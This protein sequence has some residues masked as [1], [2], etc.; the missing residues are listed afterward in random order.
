MPDIQAITFDVGGTLIKPWPSVGHVYARAASEHGIS[1]LRPNDLNNCF[2]TAWKDLGCRAETKQDWADIVRATFEGVGRPG[3]PNALFET[4][5]ARFTEPQSWH[6]FEE[7]LPTLEALKA[8]GVRMG[9]LSN[10]DD[11]LRPLLT[12]LGL[13]GFFEVMIISCEVGSRKP[14]P[15]I[16]G[17][18]AQAFDLKPEQI[19]HVGDCRDHDLE[20]ATRAGLQAVGIQRKGRSQNPDWILELGQVLNRL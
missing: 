19:L 4:L 20:G 1:G 17:R 7:V 9:I 15:E 11:R 8:R 5:Y 6:M 2:T 10:W 18:T 14:D 13:S 16:F 3:T 12:R